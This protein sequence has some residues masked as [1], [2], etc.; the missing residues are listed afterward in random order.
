VAV[1]QLRGFKRQLRPTRRPAAELERSSP[2]TGTDDSI[3]VNQAEHLL[4]APRCSAGPIP[5]D[6]L[7]WQQRSTSSKHI[8]AAWLLQP[9]QCY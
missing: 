2:Y 8:G 7:D 9:W 3:R 6:S 1:Q 4:G 5:P